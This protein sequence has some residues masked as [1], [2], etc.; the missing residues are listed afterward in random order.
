MS[1]IGKR[2]I[3]YKQTEVCFPFTNMYFK[4]STFEENYT[5]IKKYTVYS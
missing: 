5:K 1:C 2:Y 3:Y 4:V